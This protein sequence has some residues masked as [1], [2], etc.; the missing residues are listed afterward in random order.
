MRLTS[1]D[2]SDFE[3]AIGHEP[4]LLHGWTGSGTI[5]ASILEATQT[6]K[7]FTGAIGLVRFSPGVD[8]LAPRNRTIFDATA[9]YGSVKQP[10]VGTT[11]ASSAKSNILHGDIE[12][13][14]FLSSRLFALVDASADH[15]IGSGLLLQDD[16]GGG[17]GYA[18]IRQ[19][20]QTLDV[21]ADIHFERQEFYPAG[22]GIPGVSLNLVGL[23]AGEIYMRKLAHGMVLTESGVV[24][25]AFN[26]PSAFTAQFI[27]GLVFP[28]YKNFG[29]SLG[30][31]DNYL[32]NPPFGYKKN[33][34]LFTAGLNYTFK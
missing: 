33:T 21:K 32:N 16:F 2:G 8:W 22:P 1:W 14:W 17:A 19:P 9:S 4:S 29:F 11:P 13:D 31:Q 27:A 15:N 20:V 25:P 5:G 26:H 18:V 3:K 12:R 34:F 10:A 24:Q 6:S 28:V 30:A 7:T 23:S